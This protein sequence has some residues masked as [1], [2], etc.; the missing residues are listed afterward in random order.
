[1]G[2]KTIS[3]QVACT[4]TNPPRKSPDQA[5]FPKFSIACRLPPEYQQ[6]KNRRKATPRKH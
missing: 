3:P 2:S 6:H 1:M 5:E 4:T